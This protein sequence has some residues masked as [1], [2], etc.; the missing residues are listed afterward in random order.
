MFVLYNIPNGEILSACENSS[1]NLYEVLLNFQNYLEQRSNP[2]PPSGL[3]LCSKESRAARGQRSLRIEL[4]FEDSFRLLR[5]VKIVSI[6]RPIA[7]APSVM[8]KSVRIF[9]S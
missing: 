1:A 8:Y 5:K 7:I 4:Y 9:L 6:I 3:R 2:L